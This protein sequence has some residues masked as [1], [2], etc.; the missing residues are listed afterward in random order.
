[1]IREWTGIQQF[2]LANQTK[3]LELLQKLKLEVILL[4]LAF[5]VLAKDFS[6]ELRKFTP[7]QMPSSI[8]KL[9]D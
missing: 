4:I 1:M 5:N 2:P 7:F 8:L 3:L 9:S 6:L